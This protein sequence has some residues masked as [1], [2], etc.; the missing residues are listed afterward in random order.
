[1]TAPVQIRILFVYYKHFSNTIKAISAQVFVSYSSAGLFLP[2]VIR[3]HTFVKLYMI[4]NGNICIYTW[5]YWKQQISDYSIHRAVS[6]AHPP[7]R[8]AKEINTLI[9]RKCCV[10]LQRACTTDNQWTIVCMRFVDET[11]RYGNIIPTLSHR[12]THTCT[13]AG[14][15]IEFKLLTLERSF[16]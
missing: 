6:C 3:I 1:M 10:V 14:V 13:A 8:K 11:D 2:H 16:H 9:P 15:N 7:L 12:C 5:F 4:M